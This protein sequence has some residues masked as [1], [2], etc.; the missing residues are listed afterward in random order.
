MV[1]FHDAL[2]GTGGSPAHAL[3]SWLTT[4]TRQRYYD[5]LGR[6]SAGAEARY[7]NSVPVFVPRQWGG[8]LGVM[9]MLVCHALAVV[10]V[11][12]WYV[13][14]TRYSMMG[15]SWQVVAQVVSEEKLPLIQRASGLKDS[16][17]KAIIRRERNTAGRYMIA[18]SRKTRRSELVVMSWGRKAMADG[19]GS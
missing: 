13:C 1:L 10:G 5:S 9:A 14:V 12:A 17:V 4:L 7:V 2:A 18:R 3:Q 8:F 19:K 16:E 11:T 6:F 15:N